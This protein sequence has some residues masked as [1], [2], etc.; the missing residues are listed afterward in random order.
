MFCGQPS[1]AW[2]D[3]HSVHCKAAP[4]P[5]MHTHGIDNI[6][7]YL[8]HAVTSMRSVLFYKLYTCCCSAAKPARLLCP[9]DPPGKN[10]GVGCHF[11]LQGIFLEQGLNTEPHI[12]C[13]GRQIL[14]HQGSPYFTLTTHLIFTTTPH[15]RCCYNVHFTYEETET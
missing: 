15:G 9:W 7:C 5:E 11:L 2:A 10:T 13:I 3:A 14:Y 1:L 8:H 4:T 6:H 12:S